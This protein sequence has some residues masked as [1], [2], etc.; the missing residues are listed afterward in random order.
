MFG[1]LCWF[2]GCNHIHI[3]GNVWQCRRCKICSMGQDLDKKEIGQQFSA[4]IQGTLNKVFFDHN[5]VRKESGYQFMKPIGSR[6]IAE[7]M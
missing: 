1:W 3:A 5:K 7:D 6:S 4:P 2:L